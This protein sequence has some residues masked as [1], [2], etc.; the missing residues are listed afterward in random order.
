MTSQTTYTK[1]WQNIT[2]GKQCFQ[3]DQLGN[4]SRTAPTAVASSIAKF[5]ASTM[6][7]CGSCVSLR[8]VLLALVLLT[9]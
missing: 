2:R 7:S 1:V 3:L 9:T 6:Y 5:T 8:S 4:R